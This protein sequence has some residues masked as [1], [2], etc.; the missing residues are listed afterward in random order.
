MVTGLKP[1][2]SHHSVVSFPKIT[3]EH[4][5]FFEN[6]FITFLAYGKQVDIQPDK[7]LMKMTTRVC[8]ERVLATFAF[9]AETCV[10]LFASSIIKQAHA[11]L[12]D[13]VKY[14][15]YSSLHSWTL[16]T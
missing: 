2:F 11:H 1:Q 8:T 9:T 5:D 15:I 13:S 7:R 14:D 16:T 4:L 3:E 12:M 6:G 10:S